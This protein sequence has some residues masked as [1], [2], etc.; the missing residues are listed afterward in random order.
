MISEFWSFQGSSS[1]Q[2]VAPKLHKARNMCKIFSLVL[3]EK[4]VTRE[5]W[6]K[7]F[8]F[9]MIKLTKTPILPNCHVPNSFFWYNFKSYHSKIV[10]SYGPHFLCWILELLQAEYQTKWQLLS[11]KMTAL[12]LLSEIDVILCI[13]SACNKI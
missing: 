10:C 8:S 11:L 13:C 2:K 1:K 5:N 3:S 4:S 9:W 7:L 6:D 12:T